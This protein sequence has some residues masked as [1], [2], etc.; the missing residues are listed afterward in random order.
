MVGSRGLVGGHAF[1]YGVGVAPGE[2]GVNE[3]V[4]AALEQIVLGEADPAGEETAVI[5]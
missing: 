3:P 2:G 4:T 1:P 5:V